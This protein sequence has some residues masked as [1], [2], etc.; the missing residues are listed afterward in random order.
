MPILRLG[1]ASSPIMGLSDKTVPKNTVIKL[2]DGANGNLLTVEF[3]KKVARERS[4]NPLVRQLACN[5]LKQYNVP[6]M[7]YAR[8]AWVIGDW[9]KKNFRYVRDTNGVETVQDPLTMIE[10]I[11]RGNGQGD[12]D[13]HALLIASLLLSIG[14][15]PKFRIV[16]YNKYANSYAHIY[17]VSYERDKKGPVQR[18]VL[19]AI[20]K[21]KPTGFE[22]PHKVGKEIDA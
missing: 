22:V 11:Q 21:T 13:D 10:N 8:E 3:M 20:M 19:D 5:I 2:P 15:S 14:H 12:C 18:V 9:V 17:V 4:K 16:K 1:S 7:H 6:S